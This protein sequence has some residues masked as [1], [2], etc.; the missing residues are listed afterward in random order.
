MHSTPPLQEQQTG[1]A[2]GLSI[3]LPHKSHKSFPRWIKLHYKCSWISSFFPSWLITPVWKCHLQP[4]FTPDLC[5]WQWGS[6]VEYVHAGC[7]MGETFL[8]TLTGELV[9]ANTGLIEMGWK[10]S[11]PLLESDA[12]EVHAGK[13]MP[14]HC[15]S[16]LAMGDFHTKVLFLGL[17]N[18]VFS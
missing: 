6:T 18:N 7:D 5:V 10:T 1:R 2:F 9:I 11:L 17:V 8:C 4:T 12:G 14:L 3:P 13:G 15:F 16:Q